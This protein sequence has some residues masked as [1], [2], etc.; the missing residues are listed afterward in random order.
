MEMNWSVASAVNAA[1]TIK[2]EGRTDYSDSECVPRPA[3][4]SEWDAPE[5]DAHMFYD[6]KGYWPEG[7]R[8]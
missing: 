8:P 7:Y 4:V 5:W 1:N 6:S 3:P 2:G